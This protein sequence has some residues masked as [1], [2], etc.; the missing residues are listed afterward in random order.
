MPTY[1]KGSEAKQ[2]PF[3]VRGQLVVQ[4]S[5]TVLCVRQRA[6]AGGG[7][8]EWLTPED[9]GVAGSPLRGLFG[10]AGRIPFDSGWEVLMGQSEVVNY[11][12]S[13]PGV[14]KTMRYAGEFKLAG[15]NVDDNEAVQAAALRELHE[16][17]LAP[18]GWEIPWDATLRPFVTKQTRPIRSRSNLMHCY[19]ALEAENAWLRELEVGRA[20]EALAAKRARFAELAKDDAFWQLP[21]AQ[22]EEATPEVRRLAWLPLRDAVKH[23]LSSMAAAGGIG[24][25]GGTGGG[26]AGGSGLRFVNEW[27]RAEFSKYGVRRRDP[28]LITGATL[29]ELEAFPDAAALVR[30]CEVVDLATIT[31]EE[32]WLFSGMDEEA[33]QAAFR[34]RVLGSANKLNPSFKPPEQIAELRRRRLAGE[35]VVHDGGMCAPAPTR[36]R[37]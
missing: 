37:L 3:A 35:V 33:V 27:Q 18:L 19:V 13:S 14:L 15:G 21:A 34:E 22:R 1:G 10:E 8:R 23:T 7:A 36:A 29:M 24:G 9:C 17:F 25:K 12:K 31:A 2:D 16:E 5:A 6:E 30:H 32:Q 4:D 28:M 20:N 26:G 11:L